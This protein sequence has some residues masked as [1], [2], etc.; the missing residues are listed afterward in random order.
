MNVLSDRK[1][2][3]LVGK[4]RL[5]FDPMPDD[6]AFQPA[7]VDLRIGRVLGQKSCGSAIDLGE[8]LAEDD[9][10]SEIGFDEGGAVC[11]EPGNF[12]VIETLE[13]VKIPHDYRARFQQRSSYGRIFLE[14]FAFGGAGDD[15]S[16]AHHEEPVHVRYGMRAWLPAKI[17]KGERACQLM[18]IDD[19][20]D[21]LY[22]MCAIY[23]RK[24]V[25]HTGYELCGCGMHMLLHAGE[26]FTPKGSAMVEPGFN[27]DKYAE[28]S[29]ARKL[30][31][32]KYCL[33]KT[34]EM[35]SFAKDTAA[36]VE[37]CP[38]TAFPEDYAMLHSVLDAGFVDP[39]YK[40]SLTLQV[41]SNFQDVDLTK[42]LAVLQLYG[43]DGR[44]S[45]PYGSRPL[46][47]RYQQKTLA[48]PFESSISRPSSP[49]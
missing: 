29:A 43:V 25:P 7:S 1:I 15:F 36:V 46:G 37:P 13:K 10:L 28:R 19:N 2:R 45:R 31:R 42:P 8:D 22:P 11:L 27:L 49:S 40:G 17:R 14:A 9:Y 26:I 39:G 4:G 44:V 35:F 5:V 23:D 21:M 33:V 18:M 30:E 20:A 3:S 16:L 48:L 41:Y 47:S 6:I 24:I 34:R 38:C 32:G 12:Y